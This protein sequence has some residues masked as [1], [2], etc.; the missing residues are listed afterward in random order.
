MYHKSRKISFVFVFKIR[1]D[2]NGIAK[3]PFGSRAEPVTTTAKNWC[4]I[5][6][7]ECRKFIQLSVITVGI[8]RG[9]IVVAR[10]N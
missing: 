1:R 9:V 3:N 4:L 8:I 5:R 7:P 2:F 6:R 10:N